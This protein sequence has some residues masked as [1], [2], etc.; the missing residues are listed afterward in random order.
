[1]QLLAAL[2]HQV[3]ALLPGL[4]RQFPRLVR[5]GLGDVTP[6]SFADRP[7]SAASSRTTPVVETG[8]AARSGAIDWVRGSR[9]ITPTSA[10]D[11]PFIWE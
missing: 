2:L 8:R 1:M 6:A 4:G 11:T 9:A 3:A 7:M 10:V 5:R